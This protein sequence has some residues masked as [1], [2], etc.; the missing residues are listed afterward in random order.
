MLTKLAVKNAKNAFKDSII[1]FITLVLGVSI[2]YIFN[3]IYA[4]EKI[5]SSVEYAQESLKAIG[6]AMSYVS[7]A[8]AVILAFLVVYANNFFI[9]RRKKEFGIYLTLGLS[10]RQVTF[11]LIVETVIMGIV[12]LGIGIVLGI[13]GS[14]LMSIFTAKMFELNMSSLTFIIAYKAIWKSI[15]YF[16][17]IFL[18]AMTI[19]VFTI[20]RLKLI[21]LLYGK[22]KS[23][24]LKI[25]NTK[26]SMVL[27]VTS[28]ALLWFAYYEILD[29]GFA[30]PKKMMLS[31]ISGSLGTF[32]FFVSISSMLMVFVKAREKTYFRGLNMFTFRQL[33]SRINTNVISIT[34]VCIALL[35][36]MGIF[37]TGYT[38]QESVSELAKHE[39]LYDVSAFVDTTEP[40]DKKLGKSLQNRK[41]INFDKM[42]LAN[43]KGVK[44]ENIVYVSTYEVKGN[45]ENYTGV[46]NARA[47]YLSKAVVKLSEFNRL[48]KLRGEKP[49][50]LRKNETL[51]VSSNST[52]KEVA[53]AFIDKNKKVKL[54]QNSFV[55]MKKIKE[56]SLANTSDVH[57]AFVVNDEFIW[58]NAVPSSEFVNIK[59]GDK[60][61]SEQIKRL[62]VDKGRG[63]KGDREI[64]T[65][66]NGYIIAGGIK[67]NFRV[68]GIETREET[69]VGAVSVKAIIAFMSI[70]MGI[71]FMIACA[72]I[73][74]IQ[75][76][77][78]VDDNKHRYGL[79]EKIGADKKLLNKA[80]FRQIVFY[81][82]LPLTLALVHAVVGLIAVNRILEDIGIL[83][84]K[85]GLFTTGVFVIIIYSIYFIFTYIGSKKI[86]N[87]EL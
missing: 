49:I 3:S 35:L 24:R 44:K 23:E 59:T 39:N 34:V 77:S 18:L 7:V 25:K 4:Q 26:I 8:V 2:F 40:T 1:Y 42:V 17:V 65:D 12:A 53:K 76:L 62:F 84:M 66:E 81:F 22:S 83:G 15:L 69:L 72:S 70:Y 48:L 29:Y 58:K 57:G 13:L 52:F 54:G 68:H 71:T 16:A 64:E 75:Q 11:I 46:D 73:L 19:N 51:I 37:S 86:I 30:Y 80:L 78:E 33:G 85:N 47:N 79:L 60:K 41:K 67:A 56:M 36:V 87:R 38:I 14:Q 50:E 45:V 32:L 31:I 21:D 6:E 10:G 61:I 55:P 28:L 43:V 82:A 27:L 74:S 5:M 20:G 63:L 9:K